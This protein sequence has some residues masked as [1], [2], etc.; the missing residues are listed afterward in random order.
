MANG[1]DIA[2]IHDADDAKLLAIYRASDL[3]AQGSTSLDCYGTMV[4]KPELMGLTTLEAMSCGLPVVVS[5][6]GSLPEL[7]PDSRF[8]RVFTGHEDLADILQ[9]V[10]MGFWPAPEA[11]EQARAHVVERYAFT[12]VGEGLGRF[13]ARVQSGRST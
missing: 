10:L 5:D 2:F 4:A 3:F 8:G 7:V 12:A 9:D 6:A 13:Y 1:K 11:G